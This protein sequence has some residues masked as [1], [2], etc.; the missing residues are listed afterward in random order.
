MQHM[1][2]HTRLSS[3]PIPTSFNDRVTAGQTSRKYFSA[4]QRMFST[5]QTSSA[6]LHR[7]LHCLFT[8]RYF[9]KRTAKELS[10]SMPV[11]LSSLVNLGTAQWS[12]PSWSQGFSFLCCSMV[13]WQVKFANQT[14]CNSLSQPLSIDKTEEHEP[15]APSV[16]A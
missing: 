1:L 15:R 8:P 10:S 14:I 11:G 12:I 13:Y 3:Q 7:S 6:L 9:G 5:R 4:G 2:Q 16:W